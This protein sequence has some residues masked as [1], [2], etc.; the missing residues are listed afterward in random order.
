MAVGLLI[1]VRGFTNREPADISAGSLFHS[2]LLCYLELEG[3][4]PQTLG[5]NISD[6]LPKPADTIKTSLEFVYSLKAC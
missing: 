5:A 1:N 2:I 4:V 3:T 6:F